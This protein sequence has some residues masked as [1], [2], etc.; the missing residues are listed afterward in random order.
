MYRKFQPS[1]RNP[2]TVPVPHR[3]RFS[4]GEVIKNPAFVS[5]TLAGH[6]FN[7]PDRLPYFAA[8]RRNHL[9]QLTIH[10]AF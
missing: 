5:A 9:A 6:K 10:L 3:L 7:K 1:Y 2:T 8:L 4:K